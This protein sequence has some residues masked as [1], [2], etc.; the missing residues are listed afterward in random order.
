VNY[1][2]YL[3]FIILFEFEYFLKKKVSTNFSTFFL[4]KNW[5]I[6]YGNKD[7]QIDNRK[8]SSATHLFLPTMREKRKFISLKLFYHFSLLFDREKER[9]KKKLRKKR[10]NS[11]YKME[12]LF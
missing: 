1:L 12:Y 6:L 2:P 10:L 7:S 3:N 4:L 5:W 9:E 8:N 11:N